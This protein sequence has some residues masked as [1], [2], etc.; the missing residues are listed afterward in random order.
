MVSTVKEP[1]CKKCGRRPSLMGKEPMYL[2]PI[3]NEKHIILC[4]KHFKEFLE[5]MSV[6]EVYDFMNLFTYKDDSI[7]NLKLKAF[8]SSKY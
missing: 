5:I 6:A 3:D 2:V 7:Y 4:G 8:I 1:G